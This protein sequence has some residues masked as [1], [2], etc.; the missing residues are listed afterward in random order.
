MG[1]FVQPRR[2]HLLHLCEGAH[3]FMYVDAHALAHK[4]THESGVI[5]RDFIKGRFFST[6][7][8]DLAV[9]A[10]LCVRVTSRQSGLGGRTMSVHVGVCPLLL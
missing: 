10:C 4:C 6:V 7:S 9:S 1:P 5:F 2:F 3:A 8:L